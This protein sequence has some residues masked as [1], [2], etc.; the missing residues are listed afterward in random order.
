MRPRP[1]TPTNIRNSRSVN[2]ITQSQDRK[3]GSTPPS[4]R[5][6]SS[7]QSLP[8]FMRDSQQPKDAVRVSSNSNS[9][10]RAR[11]KSP[12]WRP[13]YVYRPPVIPEETDV[14]HLEH[15]HRRSASPPM[16]RYKGGNDHDHHGHSHKHGG[17]NKKSAGSLDIELFALYNSNNDNR[18]PNSSHKKKKKKVKIFA[19]K[20][21]KKKGG[22]KAK[23]SKKT[24]DAS[25]KVTKKKVKNPA[26]DLN[27][28]RDLSQSVATAT[29]RLEHVSARLLEVAESLSESALPPPPLPQQQTL[30]RQNAAR[31]QAHQALL[32]N[33]HVSEISMTSTA[34]GTEDPRL[35]DLVKSRL[36]VQLKRILAAQMAAASAA[37]QEEDLG[38]G[39]QQ[40]RLEYYS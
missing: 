14:E 20:E 7:P 13:S 16:Q 38:N 11:S 37:L 12:P 6:A 10:A 8:R 21:S 25:P 5:R 2:Q 28:Y 17:N 35:A 23:T 26:A 32:N 24:R 34:G 18:Q 30:E 1:V 31:S 4:T 15:F 19:E 27:T 3:V 33:S 22:K 9:A 29:E 36:Q 40:Q 39:Q